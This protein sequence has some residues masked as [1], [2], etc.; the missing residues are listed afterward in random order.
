MYS[1]WIQRYQGRLD[2][3]AMVEDLHF[4]Q[5][6]EFYS[7]KNAFYLTS[8]GA[9]PSEDD[10]YVGCSVAQELHHATW[11]LVLAMILLLLGLGVR[12]RRRR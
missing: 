1:G 12:I 4:S 6:T 7:I 10:E 2:A 8:T 5:I 3:D 9:C 11:F